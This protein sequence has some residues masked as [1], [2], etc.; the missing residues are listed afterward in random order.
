[1]PALYVDTPRAFVRLRSERIEVLAPRTGE[2]AEHILCDTALFE[3]ERLTMNEHAHATTEAL[4]AVLRRRIPVHYIDGLGRPVGSFLPPLSPDATLR[5]AQYRTAGD[6][7]FGVAIARAI[8]QAKIYN[9]H[10]V[11]QR[12]EASHP[13]LDP[14]NLVTLRAIGKASATA[15]DIP[16][17]LGYEG[18][19]SAL[20]FRLWAQFL[21][22]EFP[23]E[24]RSTRPPHNAVNACISFGATVV[25]QE[26][27]A[28]LHLG[29][30][31]PGIGF[32]HSSDDD[33]WALAL[34]IMEPF[35]PAVVEALALRLFSHR[36]LGPDDFEPKNAGIYLSASGRRKW[37]HHYEQ[38]MLREFQHEQSGH[39]TTM[40]HRFV[41][42]IT[43]L[44]PAICR[45]APCQP[46]RVN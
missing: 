33:R 46:F 31:D 32:L 22:E 7:A 5:L 34:D 2:E 20:Y 27:S 18:A 10:R 29:G 13:R 30:F 21:P 16:S 3:L 12:L 45:N 4:C 28:L 9:Q 44:K 37:L 1:M 17:L 8:V 40:R 41:S 6:A 42:E 11:L 25:Y 24:Y 39:R 36:I 15:G 26:L 35:R 19:A 14:E 43:S 38:R 23:F